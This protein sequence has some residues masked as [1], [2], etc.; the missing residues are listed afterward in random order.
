MAEAKKERGPNVSGRGLVHHLGRVTS[1]HRAARELP[2]ATV[3]EGV[4]ATRSAQQHQPQEGS[5]GSHDTPG[6]QE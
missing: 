5:D 3:S 4:M 2:A 1:A 6:V